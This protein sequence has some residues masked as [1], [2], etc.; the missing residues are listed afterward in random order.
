MKTIEF[1]TFKVGQFTSTT[2]SFTQKEV[3]RFS[4]VSGDSNP[5]HVDKYYA[6]Q[7][8]FEKP[9]AQGLLVTSLLG[10]LLGSKL[11]GPGTILLDQSFKYHKPVFIDEEITA[12]IEIKLIDEKKKIL[13]FNCNVIKENMD[14]A[15]NGTMTVM[16]KGYY[17]NN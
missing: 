12:R 5:I 7:T 11:P 8:F 14:L 1:S 4:V 9:I 17:F 3:D 13:I 16:Y 10:G 2:R 6:S 15:V